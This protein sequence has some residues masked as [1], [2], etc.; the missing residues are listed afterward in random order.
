VTPD[1]RHDSVNAFKKI[2]LYLRAS[3]ALRNLNLRGLPLLPKKFLRLPLHSR[4][5]YNEFIVWVNLLDLGS[6]RWVVD[7]GANHG[8][9]AEATAA[10]FPEAKVLLLEPLPQLH[11]ELERRCARYGGKWLLEKFAAGAEETVLPLHVAADQDAI[12]SLAGFSPEYQRVNPQSKITRISCKV[13]QL[14]AI[15]AERKISCIDLLKI[16]VEG[17]EF[18]VLKG[19][20]NALDFTRAIIVEVSLV[21]RFADINDPLEAMLKLLKRREFQ[22]VAV[23][24]SL[25]DTSRSGK[26][27][28]F[29][30][31]ARRP[32]PEKCATSIVP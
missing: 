28:E 27:V 8:D 14:D 4:S 18:E 24:P 5:A 11:E 10:C 23:I 22:A 16:D 12:G 19:A 13:R 30:I 7:V 9:F 6:V 3:L 17:F 26:A 2:Q 31:L 15:A 20:T 29:N 32:D 21:R 1:D 25:F